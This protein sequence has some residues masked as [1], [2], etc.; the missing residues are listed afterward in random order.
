ST[1]TFAILSAT[2]RRCGPRRHGFRSPRQRVHYPQPR[3]FL[4]SRVWRDGFHADQQPVQ[5]ALPGTAWLSAAWVRRLWPVEVGIR[6]LLEL[7]KR[8]GIVSKACKMMGY[9]RDSFYRFTSK[10]AGRAGNRQD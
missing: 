5:P 1:T 2:T 4:R 10:A 3:G 7:A 8:L 6:R 9:G